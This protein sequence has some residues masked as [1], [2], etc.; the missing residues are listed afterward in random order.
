[1]LTPHPSHLGDSD[2]GLRAEN[3][4]DQADGRPVGVLNDQAAHVG[5]A[6]RL[7]ELPGGRELEELVQLYFS[8][9]HREYL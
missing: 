8:S 9:V 6:A 7:G 1:M 3:L 5:V 2:D 4:R